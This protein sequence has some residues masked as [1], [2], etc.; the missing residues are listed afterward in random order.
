MARGDQ[1][2]RQWKI[3]QTLISSRKGKS[4]SELAQELECNPRMCIPLKS[5]THSRPKRPPI[6]RE[7]GRLFQA[8]AAGQSMKPATYSMGIRPP[9]VEGWRRGCVMV[10]RPIVVESS[11]FF[12]WN[13]L[14][15]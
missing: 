4:A 15:G 11:F 1:L 7:S 13:L 5:A 8:K 3:I 14:S 6:P 12:S 9:L 10:I 2:G